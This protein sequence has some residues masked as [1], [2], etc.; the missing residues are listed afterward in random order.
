MKKFGIGKKEKNEAEEDCNRSRLFGSK[1]SKSKSTAPAS[2]NPYAVPQNGVTR[3]PYAQSSSSSV[4]SSSAY[5]SA[6]RTQYT[7][8]RTTSTLSQPPTYDKA[9]GTTQRDGGELNADGWRVDKSPVPLNG[10]GG[11][12]AST[13]YNNA[14]GPAIQGGY[15]GDRYGQGQALNGGSSRPG[16]GGYGGLGRSN[17]H[18]TMDTEA[19]RE[20]L[21]GNARE[22]QQKQQAQVGLPPED[23]QLSGGYGDSA[24]TEGG[25]GAYQERQLTVVFPAS[26]EAS[27]R[28]LTVARRPRRKRRRMFKRRNSR[29]VSSNNVCF[30]GGADS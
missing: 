28:G 1:S 2:T 6:T 23:N 12:G 21:F 10:Y 26:L 27:G 5:G 25:Y 29:F 18:D 3:D 16:L 7:D 15:G 30:R 19:G 11:T 9:M 4:L 8:S 14:G 13:R 22:R 17:S 20:A 24:G